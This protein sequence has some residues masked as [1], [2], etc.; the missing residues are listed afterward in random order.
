MSR[1]FT[2]KAHILIYSNINQYYRIK[3]NS[4]Q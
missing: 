2:V 4:V 1:N 3:L